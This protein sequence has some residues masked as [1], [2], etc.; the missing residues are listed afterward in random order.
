MLPN[1]SKIFFLIVAVTLL[2]DPHPAA[3]QAPQVRVPCGYR[4]AEAGRLI[5]AEYSAPCARYYASYAVQ[6]AAAYLPVVNFDTARTQSA[7]SDVELALGALGLPSVS[8][9][10]DHARK[11]LTGWRYEFGSEGY[12]TCLHEKDAA[13][14]EDESCERTSAGWLRRRLAFGVGP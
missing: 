14:A 2:L 13:Y 4:T 6:A 10:S 12:I 11:L 1:T 3:A 9:L 5:S 8:D 7:G